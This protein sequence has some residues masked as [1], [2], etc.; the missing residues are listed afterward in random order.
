MLGNCRYVGRSTAA[1]IRINCVLACAAFAAQAIAQEPIRLTNP[2]QGMEVIAK[3][4]EIRVAIAVDYEPDSVQVLLDGADVTGLVERTEDGLSFSPLQVLPGGAHALTVH[5][6]T[7]DGVDLTRELNFATRHTASFTELS[8]RVQLGL[9]VEDLAR[10][11]ESAAPDPS[12]HAEGEMLYGLR[13]AQGRWDSTLESNLWF[14]NQKLP[15]FAPPREGLDLASFRLRTANRGERHA[16]N[17]DLGDVQIAGTRHSLGSLARR[18]ANLGFDYGDFSIGGFAVNARQ[19]FGFTG[20]LGVGTDNDSNIYGFNTGVDLLD[21]KLRLSALHARGGEPGSSF[22]LFTARGGSRGRV[23]G[24]VLNATP[25][26]ALQ[27][28]AEYDQS[29]FD[30]DA[31]DDVAARK[32]DARALRLS[33]QKNAF[34]YQLAYEHLGPDYAVIASHVLEDQENLAASGG[35]ALAKHSLS[36]TALHQHDNVDSDPTRPRL[37]NRESAIEYGYLASER[38]LIGTGLR[39]SRMTSSREP[40]GFAAQEVLTSGVTGRIQYTSQPWLLSFELARSEQDDA[41][42]DGND[43]EVLTRSLSTSYQTPRFSIVPLVSVNTTT[44]PSTGIELEQR[45]LSLMLNGR[46]ARERIA[47]GLGLTHYGQQTSDGTFDSD[48]TSAELRFSYHLRRLQNQPPRGTVSARATKLRTVDR[49]SGMQIED[50]AV[51]LT[52]SISPRFAF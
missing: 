7:R 40:A 13:A 1:A 20:G 24:Y 8:S 23:T 19:L 21:D 31:A 35:I 11:R 39:D 37:A 15:V 6:R 10:R 34:N 41:L 49:I 27:I 28:E 46:A 29:D 50:W 42:F 36:V 38:W 16:F 51:W 18:G 52:V 14:L 43:S 26:P 45:N 33:G 47:Y 30:A 12:Y 5:A 2:A 9:E 4:P 44:F 25:L 48:T 22:G 17:A 3:K 32:D